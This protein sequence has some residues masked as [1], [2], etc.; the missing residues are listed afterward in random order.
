MI[1]FHNDMM[2]PIYHF[3][4]QNYEYQLNNSKLAFN[5]NDQYTFQ[6]VK[7]DEF[8]IYKLFRQIDKSDPS[9][10]INFNANH[11]IIYIAI[12]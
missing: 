1:A 6:N 4:N 7:I 5:N 11:Q 10:L 3:L 8:P 12:D 2:I 9:N